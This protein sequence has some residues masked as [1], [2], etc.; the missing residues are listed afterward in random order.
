MLLQKLLKYKKLGL[1][2]RLV[3]FDLLAAAIAW[4]LTLKYRLFYL[5]IDFSA[6]STKVLVVNT[7]LIALFWLLFYSFFGIYVN[8]F[9]KSRIKEILKIYTI[10]FL[11]VTVLFLLLL[12]DNYSNNS[13]SIYVKVFV[14]YYLMQT[15]ITAVF[16]VIV[17]TRIKL[18]IKNKKITFNTLIIG[19]NKNAQ[20][21]FYEIE[22]SFDVLGFRLIAYVHVFDNESNVFQGKLKHL[23]TYLN[24]PTIIRRC[25]I[26]H[27]I[28]AIEPSEHQK[29]TELLN[30]LERYDVKISILPDVYQLL[31]G[32][33]KV[34][35]IFDIPLVQ[36]NQDILPVWQSV[37]KRSFDVILSTLVLVLGFPFLLSIAIITKFTSNGPIFY[38]QDR[39]GRNGVP[40]KIFKF[41]SMHT[42]A[43]ALGPSLSSEDDP[44]ITKWG[45]FMRKTRVDEFPQFYNVIKGDMSLVGPRPERQFFID[46][47]VKLA[48]H[49]KHLHKVKPGITSLGQVK[50]GYAE[51]VDQMVKRLKY[52]ILYIENMSLA[53][54]LR[55][56]FYTI[57][58]MIEGRGK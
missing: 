41:R 10:S 56:I 29:I 27:V 15:T 40:F 4:I 45:K 17:I 51:N 6:I 2:L 23:G 50:F 48:P 34:N 43:E 1:I 53:M 19:S 54:D 13:A 39:I 26:E 20:D 7:A 25:H 47:I 35:H 18:L 42:N 8:I 33:V 32:S 12:L 38:L 46:Q 14:F 24:A 3:F 55:I 58:I 21:I 11:G 30:I 9:R 31:I 28:I 5:E 57:V 22:N 37:L 44:R 16:K 52:D 36:I 49:Y